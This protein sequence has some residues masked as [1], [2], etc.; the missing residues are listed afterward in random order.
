MYELLSFWSPYRCVILPEPI[1]NFYE[2]FL[3]S[4]YYASVRRPGRF[5]R[6]YYYY[7]SLSLAFLYSRMYV[8]IYTCTTSIFCAVVI[9]RPRQLLSET[10][11]SFRAEFTMIELFFGLLSTITVVTAA[12]DHSSRCVLKNHNRIMHH[13]LE[14]GFLRLSVRKKKKD[15]LAHEHRGCED[16]IGSGIKTWRKQ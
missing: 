3:E 4:L 16:S 12:C 7:M 9:F 10:S 2:Q 5:N 14:S 13:L 15:T 8:C 1:S 6:M 11:L